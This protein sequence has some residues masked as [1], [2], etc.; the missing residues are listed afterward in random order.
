MNE[1]PTIHPEISIEIRDD[2]LIEDNIY[3]EIENV[4][5]INC[6]GICRLRKLM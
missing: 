4:E 6:D 1:N 3:I 2:E 5:S